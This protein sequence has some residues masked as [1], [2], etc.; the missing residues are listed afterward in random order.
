[1]IVAIDGPAG[2]GKSTVARTLAQVLGFHHL[3]TGAMYRAVALETIEDPARAPAWHAA[4]LDV[5]LGERVLLGGRDVT[6]RIRE[7]DVSKR[8]SEVAAD[9]AVRAALVERQRAIIAAGDWVVEGRDIGTVVAPG[10]EVKVFLV[11]AAGVRAA[12]RAGQVGADV[13]TVLVDQ[14]ERDE[15]DSGRTH[16]PLERAPDAVVLDTTALSA[17]DVV[18]RIVALVRRGGG[19]VPR[20][21]S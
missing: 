2:A 5:A 6:A 20:A 19:V 11:A 12:R 3:D 21:G 16:S 4:R 17:D 9:P 15:R 8:A 13:G 14:R 18:A 10:A 7:A 1:M